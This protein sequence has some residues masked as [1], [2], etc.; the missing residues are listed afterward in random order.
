MLLF[1]P[2]VKIFMSVE[3]SNC[4]ISPVPAICPPSNNSQSPC[5][6]KI[7][8]ELEIIKELNLRK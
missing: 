1:F 8:W 3:L 2:Y 4:A 5:G 7:P 6:R